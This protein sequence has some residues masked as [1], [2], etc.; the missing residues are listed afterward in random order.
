[1]REIK[2][3][4]W[5]SDTKQMFYDFDQNI[6]EVGLGKSIHLFVYETGLHFNT[7]MQFSG[8]RDRN[9]KEIYEGDVYLL[10]LTLYKIVFDNGA[11]CITKISKHDPVPINWKPENEDECEV[12]NFAITAIEII[13]NIHENPD[14]I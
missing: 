7:L 2:F 13:G 3:R 6:K 1:M 9:G 12:D 14:L 5:N 11:F 10:G 4:A 8:L